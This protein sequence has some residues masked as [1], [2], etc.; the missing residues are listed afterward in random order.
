MT[1]SAFTQKSGELVLLIKPQFEVGR[2]RIGKGGIVRDPK[3][4][5]RAIER[6]RKAAEACGMR[7]LAVK[8]S[9]VP[10][11]EGNLEFFLH[12]ARGASVKT[13]G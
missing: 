9:R 11:A 7:V 4:H 12:A 5:E 2:E 13:S 10:G 8:P 1:K 6:V 3:L